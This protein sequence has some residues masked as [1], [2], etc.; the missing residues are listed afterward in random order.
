MHT[1]TGQLTTED[2]SLHIPGTNLDNKKVIH[3]NLFI[4]ILFVTV[5]QVPELTL[6]PM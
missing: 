6:T 1:H 3:M 2:D 5:S 4:V